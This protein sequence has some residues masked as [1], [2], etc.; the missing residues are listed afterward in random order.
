MPIDSIA[1]NFR[2]TSTYFARN[3]IFIIIRT[4]RASLPV[5]ACYGS[6]IH[7]KSPAQIG[8][9]TRDTINLSTSSCNRIV[10]STSSSSVPWYV[11]LW[12]CVLYLCI[13]STIESNTTQTHHYQQIYKINITTQQQRSNTNQNA[14]FAEHYRANG[15]EPYRSAESG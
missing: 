9:R 6:A 3:Y 4:I 14:I 7:I 1:H 10:S 12:E 8:L 15:A 5:S 11:H 13:S 2:T